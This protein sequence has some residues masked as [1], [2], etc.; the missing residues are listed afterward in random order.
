MV[1]HSFSQARKKPPPPPLLG[2][3]KSLVRDVQT[4]R[5]IGVEEALSGMYKIIHAQP[6]RCEEIVT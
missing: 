5:E 2:H 3:K 1:E 4:T 6:T